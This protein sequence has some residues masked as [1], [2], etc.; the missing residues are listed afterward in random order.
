[1]NRLKRS[2]DVQAKRPRV[3]KISE[4]VRIHIISRLEMKQATTTA[5]DFLESHRKVSSV[6]Q[7]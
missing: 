6:G 1:V 4:E 2:T 5:T 3:S 7:N